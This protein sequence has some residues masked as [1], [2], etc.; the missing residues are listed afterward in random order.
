MSD[1]PSTIAAI[2]SAIGAA[3]SALFA[4][5]SYK[6]K[7]SVEAEAKASERLVAGKP[8][9]PQLNNYKHAMAVMY[10]AV[11]NKSKTKAFISGVV[12]FDGNGGKVDITWSD[13]IDELGNPIAPPGVVG[14]VDGCRIFTRRN[15]GEMW[16]FATL[17]IFHSFENSPLTVTLDPT[18]GWS[19]P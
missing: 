13:R 2:A 7:R 6:F 16:S 8:E 3:V 5:L 9:H 18:A 17:K 10:C 15:D 12:A 19:D 4:A 11:F 14:V 1:T